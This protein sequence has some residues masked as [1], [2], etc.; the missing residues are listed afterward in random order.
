MVYNLEDIDLDRVRKI[1]SRNDWDDRGTGKTTVKMLQMLCETLKP[2]HN[3]SF[4]FVGENS[5]HVKD[6]KNIFKGWL[7][8]LDVEIERY[9]QHH[10]VCWS[11]DVSYTFLPANDSLPCFI[12]GTRFDKVFVDLTWDTKIKYNKEL[13]EIKY[14]L[15]DWFK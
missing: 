11:W 5:R 4:L 9:D 13:A 6:I 8:Q 14:H 12:R 1:L 2:T 10:I 15:K 3:R 7:E